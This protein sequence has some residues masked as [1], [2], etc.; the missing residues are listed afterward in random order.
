[1]V[2]GRSGPQASGLLK[3]RNI[4]IGYR[5]GFPVILFL[6]FFVSVNYCI[7]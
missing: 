3:R 7:T 6:Y 5:I 1:M 2:G 4:V